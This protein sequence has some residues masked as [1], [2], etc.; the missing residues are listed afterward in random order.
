MP[1]QGRLPY[2][3][4]SPYNYTLDQGTQTVPSLAFLGDTNNGLFSPATDNVAITTNGSEKLRIT[5]TG[6]VGIGTTNPA[7]K[8]HIFQG[9]LELTGGY[10]LSW[11][12]DFSGGFPTMWGNGNDKT[13][14]FAPNGQTNGLNALL[15]YNVSYI[16]NGNVGIGTTNPAAK[17]HVAGGRIIVENTSDP[18]IEIRDGSGSQAGFFFHDSTYDNLVIR[19]ADVNGENHLVLTNSGNVGIGTTNPIGFSGQT[20]HTVNYSGDGTQV[21]GYNLMVNGTRYASFI[22]YPSNSEALR[23][24]SHSA[25]LPMIFQTNDQTR[26]TIKADG[27]VGIGTTNPTD[28]LHVYGG[29]LVLGNPVTS[30]SAIQ[31]NQEGTEM[32]VLYRPASVTNQLR[33]YL[34][35]GGDLMTWT[36]SGNV[37]IGTANPAHP[38]H[39]YGTNSNIVISN[40]STGS[41]GLLIRYL[42]GDN[43]GTN[44]LYNPNSATTYLDNTYPVVAGQVFGDMHFRQNIAG[45]MVSRLTI[46]GHSGNVGIDIVNPVSKLSIN[47]ETSLGQG[48][49][50]SFI[51]LDINSGGIPSFIKIRTNIPYASDSAD[52]TVHIKGFAYGDAAIANIDVSWHHYAGIFYNPAVISYGSWAPTVRLSN[53]SGLVCITLSSPGYWPKLYVESMYSSAYNDQYATGWT[54]VDADAAGSNI[55]T[56]GYKINFG[57]SFIMNGS[58]NVGIGTTIPLKP[59]D[60]RGEATFGAGVL[61]SDLYWGKDTHQLVHT[62]SGTA[63]G[64][65]PSDGVIALVSPNANPSNTRIGSIVYGN[66]VSGTSAT[67]NSGIKAVIDCYT[68]TNVTN[69][70][71]TGANLNFYTKPDNAGNRLQMT[72]NSNG[73]LTKP[74]QPAFL[75]YRNTTLS[76][77]TTWQNISQGILTESYDV[78]SV[79]STSTNGRFVAP[80]AGKYMFYAGGYSVGSSNGERYAFG[81]KVNNAGSPDFITGGNYSITDTPLAPYQ[82]VLNLAANDYVELFFF[83]AISTTIGG[84]PHVLYW[85]GYLLG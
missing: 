32:A 45:T 14:R 54:W 12:G 82:I 3:Y 71:D 55:T 75:A 65:N 46:K 4:K 24:S 69:A 47:G 15:G 60:V 83:S 44:L 25:S 77:I 59:L 56:L 20:H 9:N 5:D 29:R 22:S 50:L 67:L 27:N 38:L 64:G 7:N 30:Q 53:E 57:N 79:Y 63:G 34:T 76:V 68:N 17:L 13:I 58:G 28:K 74:Y 48:R 19:H 81:V 1:Y 62:F 43:H 39:V 36:S 85:G 18:A 6:N 8:L 23:I 51:G 73:V 21:S 41:A 16:L 42:N 52:F 10:N 84:T 2:T 49:K 66:K 40:A 78:G 31:F 80:V 61:I 11:G 72:L 26:I 37:G 35:G 70:A 33:M